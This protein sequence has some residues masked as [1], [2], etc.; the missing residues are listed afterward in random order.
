MKQQQRWPYGQRPIPT[1]R[2]TLI[3]MTADE[4]TALIDRQTDAHLKAAY[5]EMR[6]CVLE[7]PVQALWHT[8]WRMVDTGTGE[9]VGDLGFH[10]VPVD[11]TVEIGY[12]AMEAFRNQGY[13]TE[14][15][16][17]LVDWA[18]TQ[19]DVYYARAITDEGGVASER[20]LEKLKFQRILTHPAAAS[21]ED[22]QTL[23]ELEKPASSWMAIYMCLGLGCGGAIGSA[24][25]NYT[26]G[27]S[28]GLALGVALGISLDGKDRESRK[29]EQDA[30]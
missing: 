18:F 25:N 10:G 16:R 22:G 9:T 5:T 29:R 6:R 21:L 1:K 19:P 3:P 27:M 14:A 24:M 23:W 13:T 28:I 15:V 4:L 11:K 26:I 2:L 20:V 17:A 7:Y 30:K 12:G 8:A